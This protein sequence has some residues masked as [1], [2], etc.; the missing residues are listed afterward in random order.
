MVSA[1]YDVSIVIPTFN[2]LEVLAEVLH[3]LEFPDPQ[4]RLSGGRIDP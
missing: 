4:G 3:A 1:S 2:R